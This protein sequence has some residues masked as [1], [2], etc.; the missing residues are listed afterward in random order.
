MSSI[1]IN[2]TDTFESWRTKANQS[3]NSVGDISIL[4]TDN[5]SSIVNALNEVAS[6]SK[7]AHT[8]SL[9]IGNINLLATTNKNSLVA[10]INELYNSS[11]N[12]IN[13]NLLNTDNKTSIVNAVNEVNTKVGNITTLTTNNKTSIVNAI[14]ELKSLIETGS[15]VLSISSGGTGSSTVGGAR[16]NL[17]LGNLATQNSNNATISTGSSVEASTLVG[18]INKNNINST[19]TA[20][21]LVRINPAGSSLEYITLNGTGIT[22]NHSSNNVTLVR[23]ALTASDIPAL[24]WS[25]IS[26]GKPTTLS[27]YGITDGG[28]NSKFISRSTN[29]ILTAAENAALI[30]YTAELTQ[31]F[32]AASILGNGW[33]LRI[34]NSSSGVVILDPNLNETIN[35][36]AILRIYPNEIWSIFCDGVSLTARFQGINELNVTNT[37]STTLI[38]NSNNF[39]GT[40][41]VS[42][43]LPV[44]ANVRR[45]SFV[46]INNLNFTWLTSNL[47]I[48]RGTSPVTSKIHNDPNSFIIDRNIGSITFFVI[49]TDNATFINWGIR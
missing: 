36:V 7:I 29:I 32:S 4:I 13:L 8:N 35:S 21:Q 44:P 17:G 41:V 49:S 5:K 23:D 6:I 25:K 22:I 14:N 9:K 33:S 38:T 3:I 34:I 39:A 18:A 28:S 45:N 12:T 42:L 43:T 24:D 16:S 2:K 40:G 11:S 19:N 47:T 31:T 30:E 15:G 26:T 46:T 20:N 48:L 27:G 1:S 37:N 10:A